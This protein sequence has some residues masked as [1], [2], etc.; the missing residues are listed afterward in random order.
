MILISAP[1]PMTGTSPHASCASRSIRTKRAGSAFTQVRDNIYLVNVVGRAT[2]VQRN[3]VE[4][5]ENLQISLTGGTVVP[6]RAVANIGYDTE[7][8]IVWR[9]SRLPTITVRAALVG[10]IQPAT[11]VQRLQPKI[12]VFA[13]QL[14]DY[15]KVEV[16]GAV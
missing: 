5:L 11:V 3:S 9:R 12:D 1:S 14:P 8:P 6:L 10:D 7:Q 13:K 16:G 4:T 15:Y 2:A